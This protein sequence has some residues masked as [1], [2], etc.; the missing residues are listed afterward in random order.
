MGFQV[1]KRRREKSKKISLD[2]CLKLIRLDDKC[3]TA[4]TFSLSSLLKNSA[5][6]NS[7]FYVTFVRNVSI[8]KLKMILLPLLL[9]HPWE[10]STWC[11][12][13]HANLDFYTAPYTLPFYILHIPI[14]S[15]KTNKQAIQVISLSFP[16]FF[17]HMLKLDSRN[18][19]DKR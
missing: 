11:R 2:W 1:F 5:E 16:R 15:L 12:T 4:G 14:Q 10:N 6:W 3:H 17:F 8:M 9:L 19:S 18:T 7:L 13:C